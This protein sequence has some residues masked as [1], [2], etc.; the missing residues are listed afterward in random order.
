VQA[1]AEARA[2]AAVL[3]LEARRDRGLER[4]GQPFAWR[5]ADASSSYLSLREGD[6]TTQLRL[7]PETAP[8]KRPSWRV[9]QP[10]ASAMLFTVLSDD[11]LH[12]RVR[13]DSRQRN[14]CYAWTAERELQLELDGSTHQFAEHRPHESGSGSSDGADGNVRAPTMGRVLAVFAAPGQSIEAGAR[15][16]TLEA[17]KIESTIQ[18]PIAGTVTEVRVGVGDQVDKRQLLVTITPRESTT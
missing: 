13:V 17:M 1:R 6:A 7:R 11:G 16:L 2:L 3:W 8:D 4:P 15:L 9:E 10:G 18:S 5:S 12:V 14:A